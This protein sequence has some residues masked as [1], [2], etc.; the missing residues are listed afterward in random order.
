MPWAANELGGALTTAPRQVEAGAFARVKEVYA[1][2]LR[3]AHMKPDK[4]ASYARLYGIRKDMWHTDT[5]LAVLEGLGA[6]EVQVW[7]LRS[8]PR[9]T[10]GSSL[11]EG[12]HSS[13][14]VPSA[15]EIFFPLQ[16]C[17][18]RAGNR[19]LS[20]ALELLLIPRPWASREAVSVLTPTAFAL[21]EGCPAADS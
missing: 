17:Y 1:R 9:G 2:Q 19:R 11:P 21:P 12:G 8:C 5:K 18:C 16:E 3:N 6:E 10:D 13:L 15:P 4:A 20:P 7:I 14:P